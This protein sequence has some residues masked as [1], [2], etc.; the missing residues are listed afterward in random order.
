MKKI[1]VFVLSL[2]VFACQFNN[3]KNKQNTESKDFEIKID[4][5]AL[6]SIFLD[7]TLRQLDSNEVNFLRSPMSDTLSYSYVIKNCIRFDSV[8]KSGKLEQYLNSLQI[9]MT[10]EAKMFS[11]KDLKIGDIDF[12]LWGVS[13]SSLEA[14]PYSNE[15]ILFLS[16]LKDGKV[17]SCVPVAFQNDWS[18]APFWATEKGGF[19]FNSKGNLEIKIK[20][21]NGGIDDNDKEY[22]EMKDKQ[23]QYTLVGGGLVPKK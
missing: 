12:K 22:T 21:E 8:K 11:Y 17:Q 7:S 4:S 13:A 6:S 20:E 14:C 23:L 9:G 5:T 15:K 18:D 16:S 10:K 19:V 2:S 3:D 1:I